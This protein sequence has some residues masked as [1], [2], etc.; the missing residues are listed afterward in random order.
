MGGEKFD[1]PHPEGYLFGENMDLNFLGNRPVQ[2]RTDRQARCTRLVLASHIF[3]HV[4]SAPVSICD[5]CTSRASENTEEPGEHKEGFSAAGQVNLVWM[6][7]VNSHVSL[8]A[9]SYSSLVHLG[10]KMTLTPRW[11]RVESQRSSTAWSSPLMPMLGWPSHFIARPLRSSPTAWQCRTASLKWTSR[12]LA[13]CWL[14]WIVVSISQAWTYFTYPDLWGTA[15][16]LQARLEALCHRDRNWAIWAWEH[17][18]QNRSCVSLAATGNHGYCCQVLEVENQIIVHSE[19]VFW[20]MTVQSGVPNTLTLAMF[21]LV[22]F[23]SGFFAPVGTHL[24]IRDANDWSGS[25]FIVG[26]FFIF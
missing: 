9:N 4:F 7:G 21:V 24:W 2:V 25:A 6:F 16:A 8:F 22:W 17:K 20:R 14:N 13:L 5:A 10:T 1:T 11:R 15:A 12:T 23:S 18:D 3:T 26:F 19:V